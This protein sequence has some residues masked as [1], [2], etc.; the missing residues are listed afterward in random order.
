MDSSG[1]TCVAALAARG[2]EV[3]CL[4]RNTSKVDQLQA[5]GARLVFGDVTDPDSLPAAVAGQQVVYH[6]A[7]RTRSVE[8]PAILRGELPRRGPRR[9]GLCAGRRR[10]RCWST[11]LRWPRRDRPS[12]AGRGSNRTRRRPCRI[13]GR[14]KRAGERMPRSLAHRVPM[15]IVRPPIVLGEGDRMGLVAVSFRD[16]VRRTPRAGAQAAAFFA[17]PRGRSGA[18]ADLWPPSAAERL[19][20]S[21]Q[22]GDS[23]AQGYYFAACEQDPNVRRPGPAG[24][25]VG[26]AAGAG[27]S[28]GDCP[29]C[30]PWPSW[31]RPFPRF[32]TSRW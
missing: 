13:Y 2:D 3:T 21:G 8:G 16:S 6:L 24:G 11:S 1:R 28:N 22:R 12:T 17:D 5:L 4:V 10:R 30:A 14:S 20:P 18:T 25:R 19:P 26:R 27:D 31:E 23:A 15:T 32:A 9:Q 7:G 29:P